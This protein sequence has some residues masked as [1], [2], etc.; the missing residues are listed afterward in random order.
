M[1]SNFIFTPYILFTLF[2]YTSISYTQEAKP[3]MDTSKI[4]GK[5]LK[6]QIETSPCLGSTS[7]KSSDLKWLPILVKKKDIVEFHPETKNEELLEELKKEK[8]KNKK[9][10]KG[11]NEGST[12]KSTPTIGSN[13]LGNLNDGSTPMDNHMAIS[14]NGIIVSVSNSILE[15]D[16]SQ[17]TLLYYNDFVSFFNVSS[18]QNVCDPV[19]IYDNQ[20][21]RFILFFQECS[22]TS[23]NSKLCICFSKSN[24]PANDG[25]WK[26]AITGNP[27]NDG[28]WFDYP[29]MGISTNEL[30][31]SGNLFYESGGYN[32]SVL[33][34]INKASGYSGSGLDWNYWYNISGSPFTLLPVSYGQTGGYG[35]GCY[36]VST[37]HTGGSVIHLYD[38]TNDLHN[39]PSLNHYTVNTNSYSPAADANQLGSSDLLD[40]GDSRTQSGFYLNGLIHFVF[41]SDINNGWNGINYNRLNVSAL[42]NTSSTF[43]LSGTFDYSYPSI[44]SFGT[45]VNDKSVMISF[46][47]SGSSIYPQSNVVNCDD[48]MNWSA[49]TIVKEGE[50]S[51]DM[52]SSTTERWGD[53][54]GA[55]RQYNATSPKV[56]VNGM[57]GNVDN[58][59]DTWI[60]E[61]GVNSSGLS[62]IS[63]ENKLKIY[64]NP[65]VQQYHLEFESNQAE[66]IE[67]LLL[68]SEGKQIQNL[69]NGMTFIGK[70]AFSFNQGALGT[71]EYFLVVK[72]NQN[73]IRIN[74]KIII[75]GNH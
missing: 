52:I 71:G 27:L 65:I 9:E 59:W 68:S 45:T 15:I 36:L 64:P 58:V 48:N 41:H 28:S 10:S 74:E 40:N 14:N 54:T 51:I 44:A 62:E 5:A 8:Q 24:N 42:T 4:I 22:G 3:M 37:E 63:K 13:W 31:I 26:Y 1:K 61:I 30:Y 16:D 39:N 33:Y 29:K 32:E 34:Q 47:R 2:L 23:A 49:S 21:D 18:I 17:G 70:N 53:Y 69:Y 67:I 19:V 55:C 12:L 11:S 75:V 35:P 25:W 43:G 56:W 73:Q 57:F 66:N 7:E 6:S 46:L 50:N 20:Q 60:A 38:L 72:T